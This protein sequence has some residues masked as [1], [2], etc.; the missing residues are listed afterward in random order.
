MLSLASLCSAV[1][2]NSPLPQKEFFDH[3][4]IQSSPTIEYQKCAYL[5]YRVATKNWLFLGLQ[6]LSYEFLI[7]HPRTLHHHFM[8]THS[9]FGISCTLS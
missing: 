5:S 7:H 1:F 6:V 9:S 3:V 8:R 4:P 2:Q